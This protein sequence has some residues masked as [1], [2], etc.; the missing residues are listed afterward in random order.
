MLREETDRDSTRN[1]LT[2]ALGFVLALGG[3]LGCGGDANV[4]LD[5]NG[6]VTL[7]GKPLPSGTISFAT[8]DGKS[9][10]T[11]EV[12][13]GRYEIPAAAGLQPGTYQVEILSVVPTG[14]TVKNPDFPGETI[15]EVR[16]VIPPRYNVKSE[17]KAELKPEGDRQFSFSLSS[18][19]VA[20]RTGRRS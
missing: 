9:L 2:L 19:K 3:A 7:D 5:V 1:A 16:N 15:E 13:D 8:A 4:G 6:S 11:A 20:T 12:S 14:K 17:L 18:S 10:G